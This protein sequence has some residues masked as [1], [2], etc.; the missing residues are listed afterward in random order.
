LRLPGEGSAE[1][2]PLDW[3]GAGELPLLEERIAVYTHR[4]GE[5]RLRLAGGSMLDGLGNLQ[6]S[7][8]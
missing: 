8:I 1:R 6:T 5:E 7:T 2:Q 3:V 4:D